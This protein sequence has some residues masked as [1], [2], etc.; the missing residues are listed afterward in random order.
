M[1]KLSII[2][3]A[4]SLLFF[5]CTKDLSSLN[6]DP[7]NSTTA[8]GTALFTQGELNFVNA[9]TTTSISTA[10][11]RV[12]SQEWTE[13]T[14]TTEA[15]YNLAQYNSPT[16]WWNNLYVN[17]IHNLVQAKQQFPNNFTGPA[18]QLRNETI[19]AD[20]LEIY[21]Y[22]LLTTTYGDIPYTQ[23]E[24]PVIPFPIY[25]DSKTI[26]QDLLVRI[27]SCIGGLDITADAMGSTD[28]I[29]GGDAGKWK[30]FAATLKLKLGMVFAYSDPTIATKAVT[31][32]VA[33]G[34]FQSNADNALFSYDPASPANSNPIWQAL[35][36][37]GRHD[38]IPA[39][40]L[41]NTMVGWNDPR[42]PF[43]FTNFPAGSTTYKGGV[44]G[45]TNGF[46]QFSDFAGGIGTGVG[47]YDPALP[48]DMLDYSEVEFELAEASARGFISDDPATHYNNAI[49]ASI[50]FWG[51]SAGDAAT[52]LA[53]PSVAY[54]S[55]A[56]NFAQKIGYQEWISFYNRNW[57]SWT[58][59]RRLQYPDINK[60]SPPIATQ[61]LL[62]LRFYYPPNEVASNSVNCNAAIAKLPG[63]V[64]DPTARL[65]WVPPPLP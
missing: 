3:M 18:A 22:Y 1:R 9:Y 32:A 36:N 55:A 58:T 6:E 14:Y 41:V 39:Q 51:G 20:I 23:A 25:D 65:F 4:A 47:L 54:A 2:S 49:T 62:P 37:S 11:F 24:D 30:T 17:T 7:K 19:I 29:Y 44:A 13:N 38:F 60:V 63:G 40:L 27:D 42:L 46:G 8:I 59:I 50:E 5:S 43:Y 15:N 45:A 52:Y 28:L 57:D 12:L 53:Q 33:T 26:C 31:E 48:A 34:V 64:D 61:A 16:G 56:G 21:S 10:P 35:Q